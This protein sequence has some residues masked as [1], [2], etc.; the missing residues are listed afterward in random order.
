[1]ARLTE[2]LNLQRALLRQLDSVGGSLELL[3][4]VKVESIQREDKEGGHGWPLVRLSDGSTLRARLLVSRS[5]V[6]VLNGI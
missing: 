6:V 2:N 1:M 5:V 4:K 3:Q